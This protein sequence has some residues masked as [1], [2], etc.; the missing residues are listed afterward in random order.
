[1]AAAVAVASAVAVALTS[2]GSA[3]AQSGPS[4]AA[5]PSSSGMPAQAPPLADAL[6]GP[7][8][9]DYAEARLL[10]EDGDYGGALVKFLSAYE[11]SKDPRLLWDA[12]ACEKGLRHYAKAATL[13]RR[14]VDAGP[15]LVTPDGLAEARSFLDAVEPLTARLVVGSSEPGAQV[16]LDGEL[17]GT[18]P[19]PSELRVDLGSRQ[20]AVKKDGF[21]D[22]ATT[23]TIAGNEV[24]RVDAVLLRVVHRGHILVR[25]RPGDVIAIDGTTVSVA[26]WEGDLASGG[27]LLRVTAPEMYP[28]QSDVVVADDQNRTIDVRLEPKPHA[29]GLPSWV[30]IVGGAVIV[31]GAATA[32]YLVLKPS[33]QQAGAT[34]GTISPPGTVQL[35]LMR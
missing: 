18:T 35:P 8:K 34:P 28:Y 12:G 27:H 23:L 31:A 29:G 5:G 9:K 6:S 17:V 25:A 15:P 30:W 16:Y 14:Y 26:Q 3:L 13:V 33:D 22:Y 19:L 24:V 7:A 21:K 4:P 10:Y 11:A 32:A 20:V 2:A 1:M